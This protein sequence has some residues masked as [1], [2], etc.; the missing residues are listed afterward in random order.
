MA[1][2]NGPK[3]TAKRAGKPKRPA[4]DWSEARAKVDAE[5]RC[6]VCGYSGG[7]PYRRLEA[8]H[9]LSTALQDVVLPDGSYKVL[10]ASVVPLCGPATSSYTCHGKHHAGELE[11]L[12]YM[13]IEEQMD[14]VRCVGIQRAFDKLTVSGPPGV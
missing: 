5:R 14:V 12:P 8:A 3:S 13:T 9:S 1:R 2:G 10:G 4:R 6:R 7:E 11:L